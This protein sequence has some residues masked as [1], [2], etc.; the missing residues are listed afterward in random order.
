MHPP[1]PNDP[2]A[3]INVAANYARTGR[4][5]SSE[6][7]AD[8]VYMEDGRCGQLSWENGMC[9]I[10]FENKVVGVGTIDSEHGPLWMFLITNEQEREK[11][12][13]L[14]QKGPPQ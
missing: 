13:T 2:L 1:D 7:S 11:I 10:R 4:T 5:S 12:R 8:L 3:L 9:V 14:F 6:S